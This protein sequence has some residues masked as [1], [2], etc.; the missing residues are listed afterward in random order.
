[1]SDLTNANGKDGPRI[2]SVICTY[3]R[4]DFLEESLNSLLAQDMEPAEF[5][6]IVV[7]NSPDF[8]LATTYQAKFGGGRVNYLIERIAGLSNARNVGLRTSRAKIVH[9]LDDDAVANPDLLTRLVEAFEFFGER[10]GVVGGQVLPR[11]GAT[12]PPWLADSLLGF[13]SVV[14]WGGDLRFTGATEW[15][16]GANIAFNREVVLE[17]GAFSTDLGRKGGGA[18]L[19]SNEEAALVQR[20]GAAGYH[21]IYA[22]AA[23]VEHFVP[24]ERLT[25]EW[26][27]RRMAWQAVSDFIAYP[28]KVG[29]NLPGAWRQVSEYLVGL[30]P[31]NRSVGGLFSEVETSEQ[32]KKQMD[33]VYNSITV[34]L[35]GKGGGAS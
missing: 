28:D 24:P 11:W 4:Y 7:D 15:L 17:L 25:R 33:A 10:A 1:M 31:R 30:P 27:R 23:S 14:D 32:F 21:S 22:P 35:S 3:N 13:L 20:L 2:A 12:R 6:I 18:S 26:F 16:A 34:L 19:L 9:F 5:E 8:E 29:S